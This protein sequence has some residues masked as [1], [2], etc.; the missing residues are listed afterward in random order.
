MALNEDIYTITNHYDLVYIDTPYL[1][2]S[3]IGVDYLGFYHFLE[4]LS[5]YSK[6]DEL[7]DHKYKHKPI[8]HSKSIW[9]DKKLIYD[10]FQKL[11]HHFRDSILVVSYRSDGMP[12]EQELYNMMKKVK[13][14]VSLYKYG[15][16]K[17]VLSKNYRSEEVLLIGL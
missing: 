10:G 5:N 11:F 4:G 17:Y 8:K 13:D 12:S 1:N 6:W 15:K 3:G 14:E 16:Y 9:S 2:S 7:I